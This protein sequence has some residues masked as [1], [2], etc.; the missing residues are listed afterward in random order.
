MS[1]TNFI[2][3]KICQNRIPKIQSWM[4]NPIATQENILFD[5]ILKNAD[6][7]LGKQ[8]GFDNIQHIEDFQ[9]Q[10]PLFTFEEF[11]PYIQR[12]INGEQKIFW[13]EDINLFSKS[14]GTTSHR[15]K[16]IPVS[17]KSLHKNHY[18]AS[19]D[20]MSF[21]CNNNPDTQVWNG[22]SLIMGGS[23]Q[24]NPLHTIGDVSALVIQNMPS[25]WKFRLAIDESVLLN[26]SFEDKLQTI[27]NESANLN[28]TSISGVP[29]WTLVL[30]EKIQESKKLNSIADLWENI[31]LYVH[32]GVNFEPYRA[33]FA[34]L[35][36]NTQF[37]QAYNAS[38]GFFAI[39][40]ENNAL[41]LLLLLNHGIFYEFIE[42][43]NIHDSQ[44]KTLL[45]HE[46]EVGKNY[47]IVITTCA[48]LWRYIIGDTIQF[49]SIQPYKIKVTGRT[50]LFINVFGEEVIID[51]TEQAITKACTLHQCNIHEYTV[52]PQF[53]GNSN[54]GQH[55]WAIEFEH[56]P[57][58]I[59]QFEQDLDSILREINADYDAKRN[60]DMVLKKL[61]VIELPLKTFYNFMQT[62]N[63]LGGQ[64][65]VPRLQNNDAYLRELLTFIN[66]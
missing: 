29:S 34:E 24:Q 41:D 53:H 66:Q 16:L 23:L 3:N 40:C 31:E 17:E 39:Q 55:I 45:L 56:P 65:K 64:N 57:S 11:Q 43:K 35:L 5:F 37:Y 42:L 49:T 20:L 44:P 46:V 30:L 10:V 14:S 63:K 61:K 6:T 48:G 1:I 52:A 54:S 60:G 27:I 50:K 12:T 21:W 13:H 26:P 36:P 28:I 38:E 25:V 8:F 2:V 15:H 4:Q 62:Q 19:K 32:G 9:K 22:N 7:V 59:D 18:K 47:A 33:R 58:N 51:N